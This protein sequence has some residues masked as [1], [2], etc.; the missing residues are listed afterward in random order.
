M[1]I[2]LSLPPLA[3]LV[4]LALMVSSTP[5]S[6]DDKAACLD[7]ASKGQSLRD[8]G[9]LVEAREQFRRCAAQGCP[10]MVVTDCGGWLS[11]VE[12]NIP[13]I[14]VT[15][16]DGSGND[17]VDVQVM[18]DGQPLLSKLTGE[19]LP[20]NPGA[21]T[22][23]FSTANGTSTDR[24]VMVKQGDKN[25]EVSAVL[26]APPAA[27]PAA[28]T[29]PPAAPAAHAASSPSSGSGWKTAGWVLG[30]IGVVGI[31]VGAVFGIV[32]MG[33]KNSAH[34]D[35]NN[36]C[37]PGPLDS[38]RSAA[39]G[40]DVG[41]IVGGALLA[42]GIV[43]LLLAPSDGGT[44]GSLHVTPLVGSSVAGASLGGSFQ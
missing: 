18:V 35:A 26:G 5:A 16:K 29:P 28:P 24:Q 7:A 21:H 11:D 33:D 25:Q 10:T 44:T 39:T 20:M 12:K 3:L 42:G 40:A 30:G 31:G 38:G 36:F 34:C 19:A 41:F 13:T 22:F 43:V 8:Q 27:P 14:V 37:D 4:T 15:A 6:A 9:K 23:H 32:A 17:L 2:R 1:R